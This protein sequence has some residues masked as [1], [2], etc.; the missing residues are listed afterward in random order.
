MSQSNAD[1]IDL[2]IIFT[3][4]KNSF[5]N[6]LIR[7]YYAIQFLI[8]KWWVIGIILILGIASGY[9]YEKNIKP[10]KTTTI[11][12]QTNFKSTS[13][14]YSALNLLNYKLDDNS[15]LEQIG[16]NHEGLITEIEIEPIVNILEL[17]E[18][19]MFNYRAIE[20]LLEKADFED[21][22][23]TSEVFFT[24]YK[25]HKIF[26]STTSDANDEVIQNLI[27][28]LN[29][30]SK[31]N[32][33]KAVV[34]EDTKDQIKELNIT[35]EGINNVMSSFS[36][37]S[38]VN[39]KPEDIYISTGSGIMDMGLLMEK[40][41]GALKLRE[42]MKTEIVKYDNIVTVMNNPSLHPKDKF[43][44]LGQN[45]IPLY[46][47]VAFLIYSYLKYQFK[48]VKKMVESKNSELYN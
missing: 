5:N 38:S 22:L 3:S 19:T 23:L 12:I 9:L 40:K 13:Y 28:Y 35:I 25:Y 41:S 17:L 14:V 42:I 32:E 27:N 11:I 48:K 30:N 47:L 26:L 39:S 29:S 34:I 10:E 1:E 21:E 7:L 16:F 8:K 24:D 4:L 33:I 2:G 31:F 36:E 46:F 37:K 44:P 15:Y 6:L 45:S 20:P 43:F 18:K